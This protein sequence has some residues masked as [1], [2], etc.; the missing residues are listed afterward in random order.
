VVAAAGAF[1][2][3]ATVC[4]LAIAAGLDRWVIT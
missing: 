3:A 4:E 2:F 1:L